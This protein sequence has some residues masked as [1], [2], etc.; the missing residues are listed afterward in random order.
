MW[1]RW[2]DVLRLRVRTLT[3]R[4]RVE[5]ELDRE[6][7]A[8]LQDQI[9]EH[10]A[11]GLTPEA[12]RDAALAGFGGVDQVKEEVRDARGVTL[13]ENLFRDL[14]YMLRGLRRE[15]MLLLAATASIGLGAAGNIVVF[16]LARELLFAPPDGRQVEELVQIQVSHGSHASYPRWSDLEASGVL[17]GVAGFSIEKQINWFNGETAV[18]L[19]PMLVTANFFDVVG[20]P[21]QRGR[22]FFTD[23]ARAERAPHLAVVSH[24]FWQRELQADPGVV[25]RSILLNGESY[26]ILGVLQRRLRSVVGLGI[27]PA[28]YLPLNRALVPELG[29]SNGSLVQLV[30]RLKAGQTLAEGRAAMDAADRRLGRA[31]GDTVYAGVQEFSPLAG[32]RGNRQAQ[33]V[34]AFFGF[35]FLV[36]LSVLLIA[37]ANVA[38]LLIA[39]G[40]TRRREIAIRLAIGGSRSRLVQQFLVEGFLLALLGTVAGVGLA[41]AFMGFVNRLTLPIP[42][43][44]VLHLTPDFPV[45]GYAMGLVILCTMLCALLPALQATR[46][47]LTPALKGEE[48]RYA[49]R[50]LTAR[51]TLLAGQVT[52]STVL[53][54][55]AA[56]FLRNLARTQVIDPGFEVGHTLVAQIGLVQDTALAGQVASL[57][58]I[59][60][61]LRALPGVEQAAYS[62]A[63]PLTVHA[64]SHNGISARIG[65]R[66]ELVHVE[67]VKTTVGPGYF[68]ALGIPLLRGREFGSADRPGAPNVVII[69]AE[70]A[71]RYFG[72][73]QPLGSRIHLGEEDT[74]AD[75]EIVGVVANG[76]YRTIGEEQE[77][78]VYQPL[79]QHPQPLGV[80]FVLLRTGGDPASLVMP[81]RRAIV[82]LD[83]SLAVEVE[84]MRAAVAFAL[85]PSQIGA[86][87]LGTLGA[88]GLI[89][90]TF[91]LFA[92]VSYNVSRR[93]GEIAI[94]MA[95]GA[96]RDRIVLLVI[97]DAATLVGVGLLLGLGIAALVTRP[98]AMY[99]VAGLSATDPSSFAG[100][101][102]AFL[103]ATV[104]AAWI[105]ARRATRISPAIA[106]RFE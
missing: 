37:C 94:R 64:G 100:T 89:L 78:A 13:I 33:T 38:G 30:G 35:L 36:S 98:L 24:E 48:P 4:A 97:R 105:P 21:L 43:P 39:R 52:V 104:L 23:E 12:A 2:L 40:N 54:V 63:V 45:L 66:S 32:L 41:L 92:I 1:L 10:I 82:E 19:T 88:L 76:K 103:A 18:S 93:V 74:A 68:A 7:R 72:D 69:N 67:F 27:S 15:P 59:V 20:V 56:L 75:F 6:L 85:L 42:L 25:G 71:R 101:V 99:L 87:V 53:L 50:R 47:S 79:T 8:H 9:E 91:G 83:H 61:R 5:H 26:T 95:L 29:A 106:M 80:G 62:T 46:P 86:G 81:I 14:R 51:R 3:R 60:E 77:A 44:I 34:G 17:D 70:F 31:A 55:T 11:R 16:T 49:G 90:A 84:P 57:E 28:V 73:T 22:G 58:R 96:T 65:D 102:V